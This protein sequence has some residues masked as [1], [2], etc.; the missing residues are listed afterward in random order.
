[1]NISI[2]DPKLK[3]LSVSAKSPYFAVIKYITK[4]HLNFH[5]TASALTM[6]QYILSCEDDGRNF[7]PHDGIPPQNITAEDQLINDRVNVHQRY[8]VFVIT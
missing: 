4:F 5:H 3:N 6:I 8:R 1:M 7:D 2:N